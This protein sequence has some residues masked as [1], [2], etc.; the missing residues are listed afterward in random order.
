VVIANGADFPDA[1]SADFLASELKTGILLTDPTSLSPAV[2]L[3][4]TNDNVTKVF[5]VGGTAAISAAE[6]IQIGALHVLGNAANPIISVVRYEGTDRYGTNHAIDDAVSSVL[7][8]TTA[9]TFNTAVVATGTSFADAL[10]AGPMIYSAGIPL[11]L[12]DPN[13]LVPSAVQSLKDLGVKQVIILGGTTAV[14]AAVETALVTAGFAVE[15]RIA[16]ED[17][18]ETA[19]FIAQWAAVGLPASP[20]Y[21]ALAALPGWD[22]TTVFVARGDSFADSLAAGPA[23]GFTRNSIVLT[24][25][26]A[27]L[28]AGIADY[29]T[30]EGDPVTDLVTLGGDSALSSTV[31]AS[32]LTSL[33]TQTIGPGTTTS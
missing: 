25:S 16:G 33:A 11:V 26:P 22:P 10:A 15:Y 21:K 1:L 30:A 18:T 24:T 9:Q 19:S 3:E 20:A 6:A 29:F 32:V 5:L 31:V 13:T 2:Q 7:G 23:A 17:R 4:L 14:S 12:T 28:G 27:V 8:T